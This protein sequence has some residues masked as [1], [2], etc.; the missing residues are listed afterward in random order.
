MK[1]DS[2]I[3][4]DIAR[5]AGGAVNIVSGM[6]QQIRDEIKARVEEMA[7]KMD[8]VPREDFEHVEAMVQKLRIEQ[9]ALIKRIDALEGGKKTKT[10]KKTK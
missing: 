8:L 4:D 2:R 9:E 1:P 5:V 7:A 10:T 6:Q 3:F